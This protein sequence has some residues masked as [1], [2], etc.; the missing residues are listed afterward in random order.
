MLLSAVPF[1]GSQSQGR[2]QASNCTS[3]LP[4]QSSSSLLRVSPSC[5]LPLLCIQCSKI[6]PLP[7]NIWRSP[8]A[9]SA[10]LFSTL[11]L[12]SLNAGS[13]AG[14][15]TVT[16]SHQ[17]CEADPAK[18]RCDSSWCLGRKP[19]GSKELIPCT[20]HTTVAL[21][22]RGGGDSSSSPC[23]N[24][25]SVR[26]VAGQTLLILSL[27]SHRI[28]EYPKLKGTVVDHRV[29]GWGMEEH[30]HTFFILFI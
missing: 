11:S 3:S 7:P 6:T 20:A 9:N 2:T 29:H 18:T 8:G 22:G 21:P 10:L 4:F 15:S 14:N 28:T 5:L 27:K 25:G 24:E 17:L 12:A 13:P 16:A 1:L 30:K 23:M 26:R 19:Y